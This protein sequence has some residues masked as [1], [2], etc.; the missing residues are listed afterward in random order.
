MRGSSEIVL[1]K[2]KVNARIIQNT[3]ATNK[4]TF[5]A[6]C[7]LINNSIQASASKIEI[8]IDT[9]VNDKE[10]FIENS[11]NKIIIK[12]NG[13]G[14]SKSYLNKKLL[15][16]ANNSKLTG[17]GVG[18]FSSFQLGK[19]VT[20]ETVAYDMKE[21]AFI[22]S[23]FVLSLENIKDLTFEH[24]DINVKYENIGINSESYFQVT[25][26]DGYSNDADYK[27]KKQYKIS[28]KLPTEEKAKNNIWENIFIHYYLY[29]ID[30]KVSFIINNKELDP[31]K[32]K[33]SSQKFDKEF[34]SLDGNKYNFN[35]EAIE[36]K[37]TKNNNN[38]VV[39]L[40]VDND[41]IKNIAASYEYHLSTPNVSSWVIYIYSDMFNKE[42]DAFRN[43]DISNMDENLT[44]LKDEIKKHLDTFFYEEYK[45]Y[46]DF[47]TN[48]KKDNTYP[49]KKNTPS[50]SEEM[51]YIRFCYCI[52]KKFKLLEK[53]NKLKNIIY[54]LVN[55]CIADGNITIILDK[56]GDLPK[57]QVDELKSL[58]DKADLE[59]IVPFAN[60]VASKQLF[61]EKLSELAYNK[62]YNEYINERDHLHKLIENNL[63]IFGSEYNGTKIV[64]SDKTISKT[65]EKLRKSVFGDDAD[66]STI[67]E[68]KDRM[69]LFVWTEIDKGST[70]KKEILVIELKRFS[71]EIDR[72]EI[73]Q[74]SEYKFAIE[75]EQALS[76]IN[77]SYKL[78]LIS[79]YISEFAES[80][81]SDTKTGLLETSNSCDL[82]VY[83]LRWSDIISENKRKLSYLGSYL[84]TKD[85]DALEYIKNN[86]PDIN[87]K[88]IE[89]K[90][91]LKK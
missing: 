69:D 9:S 65:F 80:K 44:H 57:P 70:Q 54:P 33:I 16:M 88:K 36:Y 40:L 71:K 72:K 48:L 74:I 76:K 89:S 47:E 61:I 26:E 19:I 1:S 41:N 84:K 50:E 37:D 91:N 3:L 56:L 18:R 14:V 49:Y 28:E 22:R 86:Y 12:D 35:Y 62:D 60:E 77:Y 20:F 81:L 66:L 32:Y 59:Y 73:N 2:M 5:L 58:L 25:I 4:D 64:Q 8:T 52:E 30:K 45:D 6:L 67:K 38:K 46:Y 21:N 85:M 68:N 75:K 78:I 82:N 79:S 90:M 83:I 23:S 27:D 10:E 63:W 7:E 17:R 34:I 31:N 55:K 29:I 51:V 24:L 42:K 53:Q 43:I 15:E 39:S 87:I 11:I 13:V